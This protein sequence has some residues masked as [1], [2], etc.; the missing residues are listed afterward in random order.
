MNALRNLIGTTQA[1][2]GSSEWPR[3]LRAYRQFLDRLASNAHHDIRSLF[4]ENELAR[5]MDELIDRAAGTTADGLRAL[6]ATAQISLERFRRLIALGQGVVQPASPPF[7]AFLEALRLFLEAFNNAPSG[8]RLLAIA[9]PSIVFYGLYGMS[10]PDNATRRL[11][12]IVNNRGALAQALDCYLGCNCRADQ[13]K[14]QILLD[15]ALYDVDRAIDLYALGMIDFGEPEI[16]AA[17]YGYILD[18]LLNPTYKAINC[19]R[20]SCSDKMD[21]LDENIANNVGSWLREIRFQLWHE[22]DQEPYILSLHDNRRI[23]R[24]E[25]CTQLEAEKQWA[26]LIQTMAPGC[27]DINGLQVDDPSGQWFLFPTFELINAAIVKVSGTG[28]DNEP[29][30][31]EIGFPQEMSTSL[32]NIDKNT[33]S[34]STSDQTISITPNPVVFK[35]I[36]YLDKPPIT[37][38]AVIVNHTKTTLTNVTLSVVT[39]NEFDHDFYDPYFM[40]YSVTTNDRK[41]YLLQEG[42]ATCDIPSLA[43]NES[44]D[45]TLGFMPQWKEVNSKDIFETEIVTGLLDTR[46]SLARPDEVFPAAKLSIK[47]SGKAKDAK[48]N[49]QL[50]Y[51]NRYAMESP[52]GFRILRPDRSLAARCIPK[53]FRTFECSISPEVLEN[54]N[55]DES[56]SLAYFNKND[57]NFELGKIK[58]RDI[59]LGETKIYRV[60]K[61]KMGPPVRAK[62]DVDKNEKFRDKRKSMKQEQALKKPEKGKK[63]S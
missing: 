18:Q 50:P 63:K 10:G 22:D 51:Y 13:V 43:P 32:E 6:G 8:H 62:A 41:Q 38:T 53:G 9:R 60:E 35:K 40:L 19:L 7:S 55:D 29:C 1:S 25:L 21:D 4:Q 11:Q 45:V 46:P 2:F 48:I 36:N 12:A 20:A 17:A 27:L 31:K 39:D 56:L 33:S 47:I 14:C 30:M 54:L 44:I 57:Q 23:M 16:R 34:M 58:K 61:L 42:S 28:A 26:S 3:G 24:E 59:H 49:V 37:E 52:R 15:K 5:V